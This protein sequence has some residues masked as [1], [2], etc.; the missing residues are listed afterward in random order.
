VTRDLD[1]EA[2]WWRTKEEQL[3]RRDSPPN[4]ETGR[5]RESP[6]F[7]VPTQRY[8]CARR[9]AEGPAS[10]LSVLFL[11]V[12]CLWSML[13]CSL[14]CLSL[15]SMNA[16]AARTIAHRDMPLATCPCLHKAMREA[17]ETQELLP[18][19]RIPAPR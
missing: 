8:L 17:E 11:L 14:E 6:L 7:T 4:M 1:A 15:A 2:A 18:S 3:K 19:S 9:F 10:A 16:I 5:K 13:V 12:L